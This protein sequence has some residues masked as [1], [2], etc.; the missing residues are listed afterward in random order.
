MEIKYDVNVITSR[1]P[2][3]YRQGDCD[4]F[5]MVGSFMCTKICVYCESSDSESQ[6]V[7]CCFES[8]KCE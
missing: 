4:G 8:D 2:C 7:N 1:T 5:F 6:I 3:P